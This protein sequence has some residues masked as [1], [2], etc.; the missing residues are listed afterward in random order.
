MKAGVYTCW[1]TLP[2][3]GEK[4]E[5]GSLSRPV[6]PENYWRSLRVLIGIGI[7]TRHVTFTYFVPV[8][9]FLKGEKYT[10]FL[11]RK[12]LLENRYSSW[13][14]L[15]TYFLQKCAGSIRR[16]RRITAEAI[17]FSNVIEWHASGTDLTFAAA[18][19][20]RIIRMGYWDT[21]MPFETRW[22]QCGRRN[23]E[24]WWVAKRRS[25]RKRSK[26]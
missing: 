23:G 7:N 19:T 11:T 6:S 15:M 17:Q 21:W 1:L 18:N 12:R 2:V 22:V 20:Q 3:L 25:R 4:K 13:N 16:R 10:L 9:C 8:I 24:L 26:P 5:D 14:P